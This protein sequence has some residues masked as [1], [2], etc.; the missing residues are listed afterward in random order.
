MKNQSDSGDGVTLVSKDHLSTI[1]VS[2]GYNADNYT[3]ESLLNMSLENLSQNCTIALKVFKDNWYVLSW[4]ENGLIHYEK[5]LVNSE[6]ACGFTI[7]Y[8]EE[9]K[10]S[11]DPIVIKMSTSLSLG[12]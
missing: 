4:S 6:K 10:K 1:T 2:G 11:F 3:P 9:Q 8:P 7:T 5:G 12:S